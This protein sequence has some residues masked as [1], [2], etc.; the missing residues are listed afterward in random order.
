MLATVVIFNR[1]FYL[2]Y[3]YSEYLPV[4]HI[5]TKACTCSVH[6]ASWSSNSQAIC[7]KSLDAQQHCVYLKD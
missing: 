5:L 7:I 3:F 6:S 1:Y 2:N 4:C